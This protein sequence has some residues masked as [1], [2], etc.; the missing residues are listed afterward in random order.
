MKCLKRV[1]FSVPHLLIRESEDWFRCGSEGG[2]IPVSNPANYHLVAGV[3][4]Y[5][6]EGDRF[7]SIL[8]LPESKT[9]LKD[10]PS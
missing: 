9:V 4:I 8:S 3:N 2:P 1:G 7:H 10:L 5:L 6:S